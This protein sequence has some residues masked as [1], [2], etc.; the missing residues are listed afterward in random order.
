MRRI[1]AWRHS[2]PLPLRLALV[3]VVL[4]GGGLAL[5]L[6]QTVIRLRPSYS[7]ASEEALVDTAT[8][9]AAWCSTAE[10]AGRDPV[11]ELRTA[12]TE[13]QGRQLDARIYG[14][15]KVALGLTVYLTDEHGV[16]RYHSTD[17][18]QVGVDYSQWNDVLR[19]LR[20]G[21]GARATRTDPADER[22]SVLYVA[23]PVL[24]AGRL[25]G[26]LAVA[27]PVDAVTPFA[28][29]VRA[30]LTDLAIGIL[31]LAVLAALAAAAWVAR[32]LR[33]LTSHLAA[34]KAGGRPPLPDL[35]R[36]EL[37]ALARA[38]D[39]L[40]SA[41]DGRAQVERYVQTL[42]HELKGPLAAISG[43]AEL[44][45]EDPPPAD[46]ERFLANVRAEAARMQTLIEALLHLAT[47]ERAEVLAREHVPVATLLDDVVAGLN[48]VAAVRGVML[49]TTVPA[50][51]ALTGDRFWL[52][53]GLA[54]LVFNAI[55]FA[56][57]GST[58]E[59]SAS[60]EV[61]AIQLHVL[62]RG[63]G[64]PDWA[65]DKVFERF[66]SLPRPDTGRRGS[67]LG[68]TIAREVAVRHGGGLA[69]GPRPNGG[70]VATLTIPL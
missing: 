30:N 59:V 37:G 2:L 5:V 25:T 32:P 45:S 44:L 57:A 34:V 51:L 9:L 17:P 39:D 23:A 63:P 31:A 26:V 18:S 29:L 16:V 43:A 33:Q 61:E 52:R 54:N 28:D 49:T 53:Q 4:V 70:T 1:L 15:H 48:P 41:L 62:D 64:I 38:F 20:G 40:R 21:Y 69:L 8:V 56:P 6:W 67:G 58:V 60:K 55:E 7:S 36:G 47:L 3:I 35:G 19:T 66:F 27:K 22:T 24:V 42:T 14:V 12:L 46:R 13:A 65:R 11:V 68:L 50:D 10:A